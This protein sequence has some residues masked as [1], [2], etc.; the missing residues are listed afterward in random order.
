MVYVKTSKG[1]KYL[2]FDEALFRRGRKQTAHWRG[3]AVKLVQVLLL[4]LTSKRP[5]LPTIIVE[6][7]TVGFPDF[8]QKRECGHWEFK[9]LSI[10]LSYSLLLPALFR[11]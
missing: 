2:T 10:L 9:Q 7:H 11:S 4:W 5:A 3:R 6:S 8:L 1:Q